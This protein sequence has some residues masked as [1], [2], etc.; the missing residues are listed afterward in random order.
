VISCTVPLA[1]AEKK[2][3]KRVMRAA[4]VVFFLL[5]TLVW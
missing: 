1:A 2:R 3:E 4:R 5:D